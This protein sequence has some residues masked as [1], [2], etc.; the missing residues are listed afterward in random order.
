MSTEFLII[1]E[2]KRAGG[3]VEAVKRLQD[4]G[5]GDKVEVYSPVPEHHLEEQLYK[6]RK[7]SPVRM[8]TL[9]GAVVGCLGAFA[10]TSWMS[11]DYPLRVSAKPLISYPAFIIIAFECTI[12][13]GSIFTLLAMGH[14]SRIPALFSPDGFRP[15]F[16]EDTF[17][18]TVRVPK[19]RSDEI[20]KQLSS[21]GAANVEVKYVR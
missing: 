13:I 11:I 20:S 21:W 16:T 15:V 9:L 18:I 8:I 12:L 2:F 19:E 17:G 4:L 3:A 1:G 7:R 6:A 10:F 14:F 5:L